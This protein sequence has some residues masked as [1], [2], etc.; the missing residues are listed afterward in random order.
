MGEGVVMMIEG[1]RAAMFN[2]L[3]LAAYTQSDG[4]NA[5]PASAEGNRIE[6]SLTLAAP[7]AVPSEVVTGFTAAAGM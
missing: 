1:G 5:N 2:D 3:R 4:K 6:P 7:V